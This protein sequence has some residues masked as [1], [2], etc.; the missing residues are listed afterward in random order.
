MGLIIINL[1]DFLLFFE[2]LSVIDL[3]F[4]DLFNFLDLFI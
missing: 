3:G 2:Q 1:L 4:K